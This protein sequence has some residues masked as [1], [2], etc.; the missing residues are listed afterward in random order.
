LSRAP[1][2]RLEKLCW[3]KQSSLFGPFLSYEENK[4]L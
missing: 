1:Y 2:T 3:K 4:V